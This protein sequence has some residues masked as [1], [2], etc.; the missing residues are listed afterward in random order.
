VCKFLQRPVTPNILLSV[1]FSNTLNL[2][3]FLH[4]RDWVL[5]PYKTIDKIFYILIFS[6]LDRIGKTNELG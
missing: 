1:L 6:F 2:Y 4:V 5:H 3:S